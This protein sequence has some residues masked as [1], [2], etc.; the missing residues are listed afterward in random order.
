MKRNAKGIRWL[1]P[2]LA[3]VALGGGASAATA[4]DE[5]S[6]RQVQVM[7]AEAW[8][9]HDAAAY[10]A[11]FTENGECINVLGWWWKGRAEIQ[12]KLTA[13]FAVVFRQSRL[14]ITG[15][16]VRLLSPTIAVAH[17]PWTMAGAKTPPGMPEPRQGIEI[18]V[19]Q[20]KAGHWLIS[21]FQNTNAV[22]ERPFPTGPVKP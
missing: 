9:Q 3:C 6:I 20:K 4:D 21:S 13:A 10:A 14:T 15:T 19:L 17:V 12:N 7:Q 22:P 5:A 1:L 11:L 16:T 18:Q 8:N 2:C